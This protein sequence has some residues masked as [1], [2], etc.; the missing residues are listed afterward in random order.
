MRLRDTINSIKDL[1]S[2]GRS[3]VTEA[4]DL[5]I[6]KRYWRAEMYS[7]SEWSDVQ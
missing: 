2:I 1:R 5:P 7:I 4:F 6:E 3:K